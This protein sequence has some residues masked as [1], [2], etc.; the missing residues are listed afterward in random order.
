MSFTLALIRE[1]KTPPDKRVVMTP[2]QCAAFQSLYPEARLVVEASDIRI[3]PDDQYREKGV[4]VLDDV[5][6]ADIFIGVKEVPASALV[7]NKSYLFFSHTIKKQPYNQG[8]LQAISAKRIAL[9][10]HETFIN[11]SG[12]RLIGFGRY[13]G[14]VG[15]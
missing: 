8:L 5:S 2:D 9:Y 6:F 13:A 1:R 7:D 10:D 15:A 12:Q 4:E 11:E 14:I 3:F